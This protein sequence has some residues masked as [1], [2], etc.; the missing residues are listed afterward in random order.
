M[1][2]FYNTYYYNGGGSHQFNQ[3]NVKVTA[4]K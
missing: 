4:F 1:G 3:P 2:R